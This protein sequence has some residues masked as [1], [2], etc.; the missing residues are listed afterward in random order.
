MVL[1]QNSASPDLQKMW[2]L[3]SQG[4]TPPTSTLKSLRTV[5][6]WTHCRA[7]RCCIAPKCW[8]CIGHLH[9]PKLPDGL[10]GRNSSLHADP[11]LRCNSTTGQHDAGCCVAG[12]VFPASLRTL[13]CCNAGIRATFHKFASRVAFDGLGQRWRPDAERWR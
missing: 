2:S 1:F 5:R 12:S 7:M 9:C 10:V 13:H 11:M 3:G 6:V 8:V 4:L